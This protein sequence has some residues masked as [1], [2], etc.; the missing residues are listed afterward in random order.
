MPPFAMSPIAAITVLAAAAAVAVV[1]AMQTGESGRITV[2]E[3]RAV[4]IVGA[5][6]DA[7]LFMTIVNDGGDDRLVGLRLRV[8]DAAVL[9]DAASQPQ[10]ELDL[11][12]HSAVALAPGQLHVVVE[13]VDWSRLD[14]GSIPLSLLFEEAEGITVPV[15]VEGLPA[16]R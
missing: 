5:P 13:N 14:G 3:P 15:P 12:G 16:D 8:A 11:P 4:P 7:A 2:R 1:A 10:P 9:V 6:N